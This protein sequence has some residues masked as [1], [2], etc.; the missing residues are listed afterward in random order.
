MCQD[1]NLSHFGN[2]WAKDLKP[3][4]LYEQPNYG[5]LDKHKTNVCNDLDY[6]ERIRVMQAEQVR[7]K[8]YKKGIT[9]EVNVGDEDEEDRALDEIFR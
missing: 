4:S 9:D 8:F 5:L 6:Q 2:T 1:L 7:Y 3:P